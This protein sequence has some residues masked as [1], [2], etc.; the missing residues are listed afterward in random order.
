MIAQVS[1]RC[2]QVL[3]QKK[4]RKSDVT[5]NVTRCERLRD[6]RRRAIEE[7]DIADLVVPDRCQKD[8]PLAI[9]STGQQAR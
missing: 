3:I 1:G 5:P 2:Q 9:P 8:L 7:G 4:R 6:A